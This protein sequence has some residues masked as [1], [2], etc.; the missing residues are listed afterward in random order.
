VTLVVF[1]VGGRRVRKLV[2]GPQP[3][4]R[5]AA[6]WDGRDEKGLDVASG[7]YYARLTAPGYESTV[8]MILLR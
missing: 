5:K 8:K 2:E 4:G 7:V 6:T 3:A 1:D